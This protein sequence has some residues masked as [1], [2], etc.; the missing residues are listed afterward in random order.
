MILLGLRQWVQD[1]KT[2][3]RLSYRQ[4]QERRLT[5]DRQRAIAD[6]K[7]LIYTYTPELFDPFWEQ[8]K[9]LWLNE[10]DFWV[11]AEISTWNTGELK[12]RN[13]W[14][15]LFQK[16]EQEWSP[17]LEMWSF[18]EE[19]FMLSNLMIE[20]RRYA[21]SH[22]KYCLYHQPFK[23]WLTDR[24]PESPHRYTHG[25][26]YR[27]FPHFWMTY[28]NGTDALTQRELL[29]RLNRRKDRHLFQ[30]STASPFY[31]HEDYVPLYYQ[32][33]TALHAT[34][35]LKVP[36]GAW[37]LLSLWRG[38]HPLTPED[39]HAWIQFFNVHPKDFFSIGYINEQTVHHGTWLH[40]WAIIEDNFS[41]QP[42]PI[43]S[44]DRQHAFEAMMAHLLGPHEEG[45]QPSRHN[46]V[47]QN[48][49]STARGAMDAFCRNRLFSKQWGET[50]EHPL[51]TSVETDPPTKS[52]KK[53]L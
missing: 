13:V 16:M 14:H 18:T 2:H 24:L 47:I 4:H 27:L 46:E 25:K 23:H 49:P 34:P 37:A 31:L 15:H 17:T 40:V 38:Q 19:Q 29:P 30:Q 20:L 9:H 44:S 43:V 48:Y 5:E 3:W 26:D 7:R 39:I 51:E 8:T 45:W 33:P 32:H 41:H 22:P 10:W 50:L 42:Y 36:M 53:R 35:A 12:R 1:L 52:Y 6:L 28:W 11:D 21:Q